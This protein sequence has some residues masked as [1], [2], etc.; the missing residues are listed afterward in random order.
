[1]NLNIITDTKKFTGLGLY[2]KN[3][4]RQ[5]NGSKLIHIKFDPKNEFPEYSDIKID[6][7]NEGVLRK[8]LRLMFTNMKFKKIEDEIMGLDGIFHI[9]S[10]LLYYLNLRDKNTILTVHDIIPFIKDYSTGG[11]ELF[12]QRRIMKKFIENYEIITVSNFIKSEIV[13]VFKKNESEISVIYPFVNEDIKKINDDKYT[14]RKKLGL[15]EDKFLILSVSSSEKRKNLPTIKKTIDLLGD[16]FRLVRVGSP[17]GNSINYFNING[18]TINMLYNACDVLFFPTLYEGFG[19]PN[20][21]AMKVGLP[22]VSSDISVVREVVGDAGILVNPLDAVGFKDAIKD[23]I[24]NKD[25]LGS[26]GVSRFLSN[27]SDNVIREKLSLTYNNFLK[28]H[29]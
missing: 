11:K 19:Y 16:G 20:A 12:H 14:L 26:K 6:L 4:K 10:P 9:A 5:F 28:S 8:A 15:P 13:R 18:E 27:F 25:A 24:S 17:V 29:N 1:M 2:A 23:A 21:E 7:S 22:V 3:I